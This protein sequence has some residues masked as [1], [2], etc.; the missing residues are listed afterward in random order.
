LLYVLVYS[1][2]DIPVD[3]VSVQ[4]SRVCRVRM[5]N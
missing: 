4:D 5:E 1:P 3:Q 2:K